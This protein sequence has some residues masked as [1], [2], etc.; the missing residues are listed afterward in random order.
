MKSSNYIYGANIRPELIPFLPPRYSKVLEVGSSFG[1]FR[2]NLVMANEY[3]GIEQNPE[4]GKVSETV[5]DRVLV[6]EFDHVESE[7]P[8]GYF[9]LVICNDVIE[10]MA[11]PPS[12]LKQLKR[13]MAPQATLIG[14][15]PNVRHLSVLM[16]LLLK[17]EWK[18]S[19]AGIMDRTHLR[20][21]SKIDI[22]EL[23]QSNDFAV[24]KI[25]GINGYGFQYSIN[26]LIKSI[27]FLIL[28]QDVRYIQYGFRATKL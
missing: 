25:D 11:D 28:G 10:H 18:Y 4:V 8:D 12:F 24:D 21:F 5:L 23:L 16:M 19:D 3:W 27:L 7:L 20:F 1:A 14:S 15:I 26:H 13:K 6:G 22:I 2:Q 17:K 9:D